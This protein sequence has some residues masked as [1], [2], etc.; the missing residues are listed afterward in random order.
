VSDCWTDRTRRELLSRQGLGGWWSYRD[1]GAPAVE[2]TALAGLALAGVEGCPHLGSR[3]AGTIGVPAGARLGAAWLAG[4]QREDG[5]LP[6]MPGSSM[7]GWATAHA[8]LFWS[9]LGG[10]EDQRRRARDWLLRSSGQRSRPA[11]EDRGV[12]GH[13]PTLI[14]WSWVAG[15]HS[16]LEPTA[17]AILALCRDGW[18]DHTRVRQGLSLILDRAIP[19]GGW[20][21]GNNVVFG[22]PLRPHPA[23]TGLALLAL[24]TCELRDCPTVPPA[25]DYLRRALATTRAAVSVGWG[26]LGLKAHEAC[27]REAEFWLADAYERCSGRPDA[28]V[29]LSLLLLASGALGGGVA[30]GSQVGGGQ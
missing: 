4:L 22:Q 17:T 24:A 9:W 12:C 20:N 27:P 11:N 23:P 16:W 7:P 25:L 5:S 30:F 28:T 2:P 3:V 1:G 13:D 8:L 18:R 6:A 10:F 14:G 21:Y 15:T 26:V 29:G 19:S